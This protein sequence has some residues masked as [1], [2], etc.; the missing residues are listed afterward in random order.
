MD[1][2]LIYGIQQ[3]GIGVPDAEEALQWYASRLGYDVPIFDDS[4]TATYMAPYMGGQPHKKRA[5]LAMNLQGGSGV[6]LWQYL[7]RKPLHSL[8]PFRLGVLGINIAKIKTRNIQKA[9]S[10][11]KQQKVNLLT[12]IINTPDETPCFYI[13]DLYENIFQLLES[14]DWYA[15]Y[16][17]DT[18]GICGSIIGV[19]DIDCSLKIYADILGYSNI[20]YDKTGFFDDFYQ[21]PEGDEKFRRILLTHDSNRTGGFAQLLGT[22]QI[23]LIQSINKKHPH[24]FYNRYWGDLGFIHLCFDI[25]NMQALV[26]ECAQ[27]GFPFKVLSNDSFKMGQANGYWG[28]IEDTDGTLIEFVETHKVPLLKK[29]NWNINLTKRDPHKPLPRWLIKAMSLRRIKFTR[30]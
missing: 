1:D 3:V 15:D 16:K 12:G 9:Y 5:L 14:S 26:R 30:P 4:N 18:G 28:Y 17:K 21:L 23:E 25:R 8:E 22:S 13:K 10:R 20:L 7:D 29:I 2:K 27:K 11:L 19:S 6:E 24:I